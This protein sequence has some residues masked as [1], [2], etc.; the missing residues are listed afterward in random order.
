MRRYLAMKQWARTKHAVRVMQSYA[1]M[2]LQRIQYK[3]QLRAIVRMQAF[4]RMVKPRL[5]F[6][7]VREERRRMRIIEREAARAAGLR[8]VA[9]V[10]HLPLPEELTEILDAAL[11]TA[12]VCVCCPPAHP[13]T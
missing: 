11:T 13:T 12:L 8:T 5:N 7:I 2:Q 9:D 1:R 6:I 10:S 3:R 4:A